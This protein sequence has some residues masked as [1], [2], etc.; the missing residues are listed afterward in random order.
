MEIKGRPRGTP[1]EIAR[2]KKNFA[3]E[4]HSYA[5][6]VLAEMKEVSRNNPPR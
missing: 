5:H 6:E 1:G 4:N 2:L 3:P